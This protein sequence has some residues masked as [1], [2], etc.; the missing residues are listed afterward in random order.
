MVIFV[1]TSPK[2][3]TESQF[4][5]QML[6]THYCHL[7]GASQLPCLY[8]NGYGKP[9]FVEGT[10]DPSYGYFNL[11]HSKGLVAVALGAYPMGVDL[12]IDTTAKKSLVSRVCSWEEAQWLEANPD[13]FS[14]LW[15]QKEAYIKCKG[16]GIGSGRSLKDLALPLPDLAQLHS[17][18]PYQLGL[19]RGEGF[20]LALCWEGATDLSTRIV[21]LDKKL[22]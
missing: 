3:M 19:W 2:N 22:L 17:L 6:Q 8:R 13:G 14:Q 4:A 20:S 21:D 12:Q 9:F 11:S 7:S 10:A 1:A 18:P 16:T 5:H 15:A